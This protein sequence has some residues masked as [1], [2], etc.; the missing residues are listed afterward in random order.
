MHVDV[1][2]AAVRVKFEMMM[3]DILEAVAHFLLAGA[4]L[5][6]PK[7]LGAAFDDTSPCTDANCA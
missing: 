6:G 2:G 3:F 1:A 4:N 5:V 7:H